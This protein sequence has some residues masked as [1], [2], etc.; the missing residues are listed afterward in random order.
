MKRE[1]DH[2]TFDAEQEILSILSQ[3]HIKK[4]Q[5]EAEPSPTEE[6]SAVQTNIPAA[7]DGSGTSV[8]GAP[9]ILSPDIDQPQTAPK[10]SRKHRAAVFAPV[11]QTEPLVT[12]TT[13]ET[14]AEESPF[15]KIGRAIC[16]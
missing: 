11:V 10:P 7:P 1:D 5:E 6:E 4:P 2:S 12:D 13:S 14:S 3:V 9:L 15:A 8:E 16:G